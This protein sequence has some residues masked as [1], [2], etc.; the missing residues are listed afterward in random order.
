MQAYTQFQASADAEEAQVGDLAFAK[1][2]VKV[3]M[4]GKEVVKALVVK[5]RLASIA[6]TEKQAHYGRTPDKPP[7]DYPLSLASK[8]HP[9]QT[10]K[11]FFE[12]LAH[13]LVHKP[14]KAAFGP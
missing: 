7:L 1:V 6:V 2:K 8:Y 4:A 11:R 10:L 5:S 14:F 12:P 13:V 3:A 9:K